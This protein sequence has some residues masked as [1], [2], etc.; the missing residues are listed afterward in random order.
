M[1]RIIPMG[2][3]EPLE[4]TWIL[5]EVKDPKNWWGGHM[6]TDKGRRFAY[7]AS[8]Y[9]LDNIWYNGDLVK[10]EEVR[11]YEDLLNPKW[12]NKIGLLDPR[13]GGAGIGIW[14]FLWA[15]KG[16]GFL[17]KLMDQQLAVTEDRVQAD[18]FTRGKLA[19]ALGPTY[20]KFESFLQGRSSGE[21][22]S[23][24]QRRNLRVCGN[25]GARDHQELPPSQ[26][27]QG[28]C[29][30]VSQQRRARDLRQ[31]ARTCNSSLGCGYQMDAA[32]W[33]ESGKG[34]DKRGG[35]LQAR[36]SVGGQSSYRA[37]ASARVC[38]EGLPL[39]MSREVL[40][41]WHW[42][43]VCSA[44][45]DA[46]RVCRRRFMGPHSILLTLF[47]VFLFQGDLHPAEGKKLERV[48]VANA[49]VSENRV[50]LWIAKDMGIF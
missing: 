49:V 47:F 18:S 50:P 7:S 16:E 11:S 2:A 6:W 48:I 20:Y 39:K 21:A 29:Q 45:G 28:F 41:D 9:M 37:R 32:D 3:V 4:P 33:R 1:D 15:T 23:T 43:G 31:S 38:A 36:E 10:P 8:A 14:G 26:C 44:L 34:F 24:L 17:K 19:I 30:L 35:V 13:L 25:W 27:C 42:S 46:P 22:L 5:P 40:S 12:K